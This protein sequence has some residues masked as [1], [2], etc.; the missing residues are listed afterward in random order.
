[1]KKKLA[2]KKMKQEQG[3][4]NVNSNMST[5]PQVSEEQLFAM[6]DEK[7]E[8]TP[9]VSSASTNAEGTGT[10]KKKKKNKNKK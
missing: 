2:E 1:M 4:Q 3:Q 7:P 9:R 5:V 6:F 8:R 10:G